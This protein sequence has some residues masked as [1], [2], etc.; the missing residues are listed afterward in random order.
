[1][2]E[3][4]ELVVDGIHCASCGLL[5]DETV[6]ELDGV[7]RCQTDVRR[8]RARVTYDPDR[9]VIDAIVLAITDAGYSAALS[10]PRS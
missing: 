4:I 6:E 8:A 9:V 5:I 1:M 3:S 7:E 10:P 2:T